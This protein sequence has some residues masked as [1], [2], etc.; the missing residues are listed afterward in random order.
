MRNYL[1]SLRRHAL[2]LILVLAGATAAQAQLRAGFTATPRSGCAPI[3]VNFIDTSSGV[4][5]SWRWDLG[6][7]TI[8]TQRS[9]ST[10]YLTPGTYTV[11]LVVTNATG[12]D[13][14]AKVDYITV[15]P[16]PTVSFRGIDSIGCAPLTTAFTS[17]ITSTGSTITSLLWDLGDGTSANTATATHV[18]NTPGQYNISLTATNAAGCSKT[19]DTPAYIKVGPKPVASFT[20]SNPGN[21]TLP[22]TVNFTATTPGAGNTYTWD[23]GDNSTGTGANPSHTY[24][25]AGSYT[26]KMVVTSPYTCRDSVIK[27]ALVQLGSTTAFTSNATICVGQNVAFTNNSVPTAVSQ[28]WDFG[29]GTNSNNAVPVKSYAT[30]GTYTITLTNTYSGG[31]T[32]SSTR[33]ITVLPKPTIA[34]TADRTVA[35]A[36][37]LTVNFTSTVTNGGTYLWDFGDNTTSTQA[38]PSHTYTAVGAYIVSLTVTNASGC[39]ERLEKYNFIYIQKPQITLAGLPKGGC[40]PL[41]VNPVPTVTSIEPITSYAWNFGDGVGTSTQQNPTYT[42]NALGTYNVTLT[43]TTASGCTNTLVVSNAATIDPKPGPEFTNTPAQLCARMPVTFTNVSTGTNA[44]TFYH[45]EFGDG[46]SSGLQSPTH[47]YTDTG[48]FSVLLVV[49]N[50]QCIDSIRH[51]KAVRVLPPLANFD[52]S[53][54]CADKMTRGFTDRSKVDVNLSPL[55]YEWHFGD[56]N[57][58][59]IPSPSHTYGATGT[60]PVMLVVVNGICRDT[61]AATVRI[62]NETANFSV[63][64]TTVCRNAPVDFTPTG[65]NLANVSSFAWDFG[66]GT[67]SSVAG[68]VS[69]NYNLN[70][71]YTVTLLVTDVNG[72]TSSF[73]R[74]ITVRGPSAS[75]TPLQTTQCLLPG[76]NPVTFNAAVVTDPGFPVV[77]YIW[78]FGDN[79]NLDS[80]S[81]ISATHTY[82]TPGVYAISLT[83]RDALGCVFNY[84]SAPDAVIISKPT[85]GFSSGD[86]ITCTNRPITFTNTSTGN[87]PLQYD[88]HFGDN[89]TGT[90][91]SPV[92]NYSATGIYGVKLIVTD[93]FGC[94][95]S[96]DRPNYINISFPHA[97]FSMRSYTANCPPLDDTIRNL[98]TDYLRSAWDFGDGST[99]SLNSPFH[100]YSYA[101]SYNLKL[102]VTGPG[103]CTDDTTM[104]IDI[105]GPS[106]SFTYAPLKGCMPFTVD[107]AA[108]TQ[109]RDSI[110]WDYG[111]GNTWFTKSETASHVYSDTGN[112]QPRIILTDTSGCSVSIFGDEI[113]HSYK[114][115]P[116]LDASL[117][118]LCDSGVVNFSGLSASNDVLTGWQWDFGDGGSATVQHPSHN[119]TTPGT[120]TVTLTNTSQFGCTGTV[121]TQPI[122]VHV[123]PKIAVV[124]PAA[125]ACAPATFSFAGNVTRNVPGTLTWSWTFGNGNTSTAQNPTAQVY[126]VPNTYRIRALVTHSNGCTDS[127]F[128]DVLVRPLPVVDA[129]ADVPL[130]RDSVFTLN[131]SGALTYVWDPNGTLS[132]LACPNPVASPTVNTTYWVTGTDAFG[133][134]GRDFVRVTVRQPFPFIRPVLLDTMCAGARLQLDARGADIYQWSPRTY[135]NDSTL[136]NPTITPDR[137]TVITYMLVARDSVGCRRDTAFTTIR[138]YPVPQ[139]NA[140][141]DLTLAAGDT[142]R[143]RSTSSPD[144]LTWRWVPT[145]GLNCNDCPQPVL[146]AVQSQL[147]RVL[148]RNE[149]GCTAFDDLQVTVTCGGGNVFM[150][151][152]FSPNG[153][154][155]NDKLYPR[156]TGIQSIKSLRIF[157][158]WGQVVYERLNLKANN[159][160]D[161]WDGTIKGVKAPSDVYVYTLEVLC[162]NNEVVPIKGDVTLIQ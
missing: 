45:W 2:A 61:A 52:V 63:S 141:P 4:P 71:T 112:F 85:V 135:L 116:K 29:D 82:S 96:T 101:G 72:C 81:T 50:G 157:N 153:D 155:M 58:A 39:S 51:N 105:K 24:T 162:V 152:T 117:F 55:T 91:Q 8:S 146:R 41:Q 21:C 143:F 20:N 114:V 54:L 76:G 46:N 88:W 28:V 12:S 161:G 93:A 48:Y 53:S 13:S 7:N 109:H 65:I 133:C 10:T 90:Q 56:G 44:G 36:A 123:S 148:V 111:D 42:Y 14:V 107:F 79:G 104:V 33:T 27:T 11:R 60:Y 140:G 86:T 134:S 6:N 97:S 121:S 5:T 118:N 132:C 115:Y 83:I 95:D 84:S 92:H 17:S 99:S 67:G 62:V 98:S 73:S 26:V 80:A 34:F 66:D 154:G 15:L 19:V 16:S 3:L 127:A 130:C 125:A 32:N 131:P 137:D 30:A 119:Y 120:Y 100:R 59:A 128:S 158:R 124:P 144:I 142:V 136:A 40:L 74:D 47:L 94:K 160:L 43:V 31:C 138:V 159:P 64:A 37:P 77:G 126:P 35:C 113:V 139:I 78:N 149:G 87:G 103:G 69:H 22:F 145:L 25:A 18:Y 156:G 75:V 110:I 1:L 70:N 9:P 102:T 106:G 151:N 89:T 150:P 49:R 68:P 38:N 57:T 122:T 147:Y 108:T 129:G 23:F